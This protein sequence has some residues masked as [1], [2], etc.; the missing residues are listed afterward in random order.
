M[1]TTVP[2]NGPRNV[3]IMR[4]ISTQL[5]VTWEPLSLEEA[6]GFITH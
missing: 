4:P 2:D 6:R 3:Q 5:E 1:Y